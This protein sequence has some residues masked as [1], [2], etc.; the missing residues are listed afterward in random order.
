MGR[1]SVFGIIHMLWSGLKIFDYGWIKF[2]SWSVCWQTSSILQLL[3]F[4]NQD[5][6]KLWLMLVSATAFAAVSC[7]RSLQASDNVFCQIRGFQYRPKSSQSNNH[8]QKGVISCWIPAKVSLLK[9]PNS[10]NP[11]LKWGQI[12]IG[13]TEK[14]QTSNHQSVAFWIAHTLLTTWWTNSHEDHIRKATL[15]LHWPLSVSHSVTE[16]GYYKS[17]SQVAFCYQDLLHFHFKCVCTT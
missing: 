17:N 5:D 2:E 12:P 8:S 9:I 11:H 13:L 6:P 16:W 7:F 4:C 10:C 3:G 15:C 1:Q 14:L